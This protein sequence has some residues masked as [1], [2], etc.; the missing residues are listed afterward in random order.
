V[1]LPLQTLPPLGLMVRSVFLDASLNRKRT[2][3]PD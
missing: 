1:E 2:G 3:E